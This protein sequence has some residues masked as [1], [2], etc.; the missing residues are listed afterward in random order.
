MSSQHVYPVLLDCLSCCVGFLKAWEDCLLS[1]HLSMWP[2]LL[3]FPH[4]LSLPPVC[5]CD[6]QQI[7]RTLDVTIITYTHNVKNQSHRDLPIFVLFIKVLT[8][9]FKSSNWLSEEALNRNSTSM[10]FE[11]GTKQTH[12]H[13]ELQR[14]HLCIH[15]VSIYVLAVLAFNNQKRQ[16]LNIDL[17]KS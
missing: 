8:K 9:V 15:S 14:K 4:T 3:I 6:L 12:T 10:G 1:V 17:T 16:H 5:D 13:I 11:H 7:S 2:P